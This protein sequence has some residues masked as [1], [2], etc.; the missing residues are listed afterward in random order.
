MT[1]FNEKQL[2]YITD[3]GLFTR[4]VDRLRDEGIPSSTDTFELVLDDKTKPTG[5]IYKVGFKTAI[6]YGTKVQFIVPS[7]ISYYEL[8]ELYSKLINTRGIS[9][10]DM[11]YLAFMFSLVVCEVEE[12]V[13]FKK[14]KEKCDDLLSEYKAQKLLRDTDEEEG[15]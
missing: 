8:S 3:N 9:R 11:D 7:V 5:T 1:N 15:K 14:F 13:D 10:A 2:A 12:N 6:K 4:S